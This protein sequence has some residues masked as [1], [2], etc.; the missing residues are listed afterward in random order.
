MHSPAI[1]ASTGQ[2]PD[3]LRSPSAELE[4]SEIGRKHV[5]FA[6]HSDAFEPIDTVHSTYA[7][8]SAC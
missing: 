4:G 6:V 8:C 1:I 5:P 2:R 7:G 3:F